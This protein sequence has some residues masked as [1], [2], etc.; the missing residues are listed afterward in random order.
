M[1]QIQFC[2]N[3]KPESSEH[4][5]AWWIK[6]FDSLERVER[7]K[8]RPPVAEVFN[9]QQL[10]NAPVNYSPSRRTNVTTFKEKKMRSI[11]Y[12]HSKDLL[13]QF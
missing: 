4:T 11:R 3:I 6:S 1:N 10:L 13:A 7:M 12:I 5:A 2:M 9:G 8:W